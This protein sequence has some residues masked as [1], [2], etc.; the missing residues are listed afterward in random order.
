VIAGGRIERAWRNDVQ[1]PVSRRREALT[2]MANSARTRVLV[3]TDRIATCPELLQAIRARA[4]RGLIDVRSFRT[5]LSRSSC[6][7]H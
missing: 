5:S 3:V 6:P 7:S 1:E 2:L 4:E